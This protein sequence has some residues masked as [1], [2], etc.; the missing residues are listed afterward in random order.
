MHNLCKVANLYVK[1][2]YILVV[3]VIQYQK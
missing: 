1:M 3:Q 2:G